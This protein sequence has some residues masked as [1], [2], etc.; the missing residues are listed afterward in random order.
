MTRPTRSSAVA[1]P[2]QRRRRD[3]HV[4]DLLEV[5]ERARDV[6]VDQRARRRVDADVQRREL[7]GEVPRQR[8][9]RGLRR[10][11]D[12]VVRRHEVG[13]DRRDVDDAAAASLLHQR[14][15][16]A[17]APEAALDVG[18]EAS[19]RT[20]PRRRPRRDQPAG[21]GVVDE[22]VEVAEAS[23]R[24]RRTSA[25]PASAARPRRGR[26][27]PS[28]RTP[29]ARPSSPSPLERVEEVERGCAPRGRRAPGRRPCR[30]PCRPR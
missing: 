3:R 11:D 16:G 18:V 15:R 9:E 6:A 24:S 28:R 27:R 22:D 29:R 30:R 25:R 21:R 14:R 17:G 19:A 1:E 26:G 4:D 7:D 13:A 5:R 20:P 2:P 23:P 8:L 12:D 10:A